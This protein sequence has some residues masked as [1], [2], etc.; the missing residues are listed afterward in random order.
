MSTTE[1]EPDD[2]PDDNLEEEEAANAE[3]GVPAWINDYP[4]A[5]D[6]VGQDLG[7]AKRRGLMFHWVQH[8]SPLKACKT[9]GSMILRWFPDLSLDDT[10]KGPSAI[11]GDQKAPAAVFA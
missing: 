9:C 11:L 4:P 7:H 5:N 1:D 10:R 8:R 6:Q 3:D 2:L